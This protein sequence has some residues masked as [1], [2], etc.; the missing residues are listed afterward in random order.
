MDVPVEL[1]AAVEGGVDLGE[2]N[3]R[4]PGGEDGL[5]ELVEG[6]EEEDFVDVVGEQGK[7]ETVGE[8]RDERL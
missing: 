7:G 1:V 8:R 4:D 3:G 2:E 5:D 6:E